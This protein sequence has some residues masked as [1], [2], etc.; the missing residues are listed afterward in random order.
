MK[1]LMQYITLVSGITVLCLFGINFIVERSLKKQTEDVYGKL[2][3]IFE[4]KE[5]FDLL[6]VGSSRGPVQI[7]PMVIDTI[8]SINS[9]NAGLDGIS[10]VEC[11]MVIES[12]LDKHQAP[13]ALVLNMDM[14]S[15]EITDTYQEFDY[16]LFLPY[17]NHKYVKQ[18]LYEYTPSVKFLGCFPFLKPAYY[19]DFKKYLA[20]KAIAHL[21]QSKKEYF[22]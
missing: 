12:Y 19:N 2:N 22:V 10:I 7:N 20:L 14:G 9:F 18:T 15:M 4:G 16:P 21:K 11:K 13:Q 1:K 3:E 5:N 17:L 8:L 6:F